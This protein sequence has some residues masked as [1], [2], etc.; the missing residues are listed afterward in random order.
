MATGEETETIITWSLADEYATVCS[1][2][3]KVW[4]RCEAV[5]GIERDLDGGVRNGK[6]EARM[7]LIDASIIAIRRPRKLAI[8][9]QSRARLAD[10]MRDVTKNRLGERSVAPTAA[11]QLEPDLAGAA[12]ARSRARSS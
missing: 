12:P 1:L 4:R 5:G 11:G 3:P 2:M 7:F 8:G 10:A 9:P 6:R